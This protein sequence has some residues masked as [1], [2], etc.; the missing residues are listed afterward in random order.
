MK[1]VGCTK[2]P[3]PVFMAV[4]KDS[5]PE[6]RRA[7]SSLP[8]AAKPRTLSYC[9]RVTWGPWNV[10]SSKGLPTTD[11]LLVTSLNDWMKLS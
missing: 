11:S 3:F 10:L 5:P 8:D 1:M 9:V 2:K 7:P 4:G 6:M